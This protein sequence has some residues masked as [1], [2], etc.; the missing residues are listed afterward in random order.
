MLFLSFT[1]DTVKTQ[2]SPKG[3]EP[4]RS[5]MKVPQLDFF[6]PQ[7]PLICFYYND[8]TPS[9]QCQIEN[10]EGDIPQGHQPFAS[11]FYPSYTILWHSTLMKIT[12]KQASPRKV[13]D[14]DFYMISAYLTV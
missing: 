14:G 7:I 13:S 1:G 12:Q 5:C 11:L 3:A 6:A 10:M 9:F 2:A 4:M 8:F